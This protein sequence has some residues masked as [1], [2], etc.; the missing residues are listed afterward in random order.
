LPSGT[1]RP[2][3]FL[4]RDGVLNVDH[5]FVHR[6]EQVQ[7][8][9]GARQA[10]K[11]LNEAGYLVFVVTNQSGVARGLYD[12]AAVAALHRWMQ[13]ELA[14]VG[15]HID[16]WRYCP[17]HPEAGIE[18]YHRICACRKPEP[19]MILDIIEHWPVDRARSFL[20]GDQER[21][22][23]AARAAGIAGHLFTGGDLDDLVRSLLAMR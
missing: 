7:W 21:D 20:I 1:P 14:T 15:A 2:A 6:P 8:M 9:P 4:D 10:V 23:A 18:A 11:R 22:M 12:E 17:H 3:A 16:D 13:A 5:G 19:G